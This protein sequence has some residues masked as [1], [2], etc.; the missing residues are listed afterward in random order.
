[1]DN[2]NLTQVDNS[3]NN[4]PRTPTRV[5]KPHACK[6]CGETNPEQFYTSNKGRCKKCT[7][8]RNNHRYHSL[9][10]PDKETYKDRSKAWQDDNILLYRWR[11]ARNRAAKKGLMFSITE[12]DILTLWW[13]QDGLCHY[14]GQP[15]KHKRDDSVGGPSTQSVSLDRLDNNIGYVNGNVVLCLASVNTMK[16]TMTLQEFKELITVLSERIDSF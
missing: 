11:S 9:T 10:D 4:T 7:S 14:T 3:L 2:S 1:M 12:Q 5:T 15:M 16:N 8:A 13:Q 6:D